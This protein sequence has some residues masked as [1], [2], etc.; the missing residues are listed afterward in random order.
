M[1]IESTLF[2]PNTQHTWPIAL[3]GDSKLEENVVSELG[4]IRKIS[5]NEIR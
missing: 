4:E 3:K 5:G 1:Q 2:L